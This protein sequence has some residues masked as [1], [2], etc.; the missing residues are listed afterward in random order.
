MS[1]PWDFYPVKGGRLSYWLP[2]SLHV[3]Q[4]GRAVCIEHHRTSWAKSNMIWESNKWT[5]SFDDMSFEGTWGAYFL[6][7]VEVFDRIFFGFLWFFQ[8]QCWKSAF[9][10][11]MAFPPWSW[12]GESHGN[13]TSEA[14]S[15]WGRW[16]R[17]F[18]SCT[19]FFSFFF[20]GEP[21]LHV[22]KWLGGNPNNPVDTCSWVL[23]MT[24]AMRRCFTSPLKAREKKGGNQNPLKTNTAPQK[25]WLEDDPFLLKW[26]LFS[27][28]DVR[29]LSGGVTPATNGRRICLEVCR[30]RFQVEGLFVWRKDS[31]VYRG[32]KRVQTSQ[33]QTELFLIFYVVKLNQLFQDAPGSI[34]KYWL[35]R[36]TFC[37]DMFWAGWIWLHVT[38]IKP[39]STEASLLW[40]CQVTPSKSRKLG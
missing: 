14:R 7:K 9:L 11:T 19:C 32:S 36:C 10:E 2:N 20:S 37:I 25:W 26:S 1:A 4:L 15:A 21:T 38:R 8:L 22:G 40:N 18:R 31:P 27:Q 28:G 6:K 30:R 12:P 23:L 35:G 3:F 13:I 17:I 34:A 5:V 24:D 29:S 33:Q 16:R 39:N